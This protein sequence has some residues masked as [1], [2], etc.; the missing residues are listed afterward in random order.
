MGKED[1]EDYTQQIL[2]TE[3]EWMRIL[4]RLETAICEG[5]EDAGFFL[6]GP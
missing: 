2:L 1:P 3:E 4:S 6:P 5:L